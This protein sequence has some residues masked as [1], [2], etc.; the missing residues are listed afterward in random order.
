METQSSNQIKVGLLVFMGVVLAMAF[1]FILGGQKQLFT[2]QYTLI[3]YFE[4]IS[5]LRVGAP[6]QLAGVQVGMVDHISL[7]TEFKDL[8]DKRVAVR[9]SIEK[10]FQERIRGDSVASITTQGLLGDK[11]ISISLGTPDHEAL[12]DNA[13]ILSEE[14]PSLFA[15]AEKGGAIMENINGAAKSITR[16]L[17]ELEKG[18]GLLHTL[19]YE[20]EKKPVAKNIAETTH[21]LRLASKEAREILEKINRGEGTIGALLSDPSVYHDIRGL[22]GKLQRNWLLRFVVRSRIRDMEMEKVSNQVPSPSRE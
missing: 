9:L 18:E 21:D 5:G 13:V 3:A 4:D 12:Q 10:S 22:L 7:G 15:L 11:N 16:I 2:R 14:H 6:I 8:Q 20:T 17:G 1:I 19:I